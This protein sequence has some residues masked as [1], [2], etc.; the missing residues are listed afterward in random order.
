MDYTNEQIEQVSDGVV[1]HCSDLID[2][3]CTTAHQKAVSARE[4]ER[5]LAHR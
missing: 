3:S 2:N 4:S 1:L 5:N